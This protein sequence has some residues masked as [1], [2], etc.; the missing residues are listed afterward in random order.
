M[1]NGLSNETEPPFIPYFFRE[2]GYP[3]FLSVG[4]KIYTL[5]GGTAAYIDLDTYDLSASILDPV[6]GS[7]VFLRIWQAVIDSINV[8]LL[9]LILTHVINDHKSFIIAL[10]YA[11]YLPVA[12]HNNHLY[13]EVFHTLILLALNLF[14]V[15]Y[16]YSKRRW[17]LLLVGLFW[18]V[19]NVTFQSTVYLFPFLFLMLLV[20]FRSFKRAFIDTL[21]VSG[22]MVSLIL[23]WLIY[24]YGYYP[25]IRIAKTVGCALTYE[26]IHYVSYHR[27]ANAVGL[28]SDSELARFEYEDAYHG[29]FDEYFDKSFNGYYRHKTDS[30]RVLVGQET[31][32]IPA[33]R[34]LAYMGKYLLINSFKNFWMKRDW[35]WDE[36]GRYFLKH[37][38]ILPLILYAVSAFFAVL[39]FLGFLK[40]F[41]K[42]L[43]ILLIFI[44]FFGISY[45]LGAEPRRL[46]PSY[47]YVFS[48]WNTFH[49]RYAAKVSG[50]PTHSS[51]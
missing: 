25:D 31:K 11:L 7:V 27:R 15:K 38:M 46:L 19:S 26:W 30:L 29:T 28:M 44:S 51:E 2:P 45:I 43:P 35:G 42:F 23:P 48:F 40:Y 41:R 5:F 21:I 37:R 3:V 4:L 12:L 36:P 24:V 47:P 8:L 33:S 32:D 18:A 34:K 17:F 6:P 49:Y 39:C 20:I 16:L 13:R 14:F 9:F 10:C 22:V 50:H 1:G